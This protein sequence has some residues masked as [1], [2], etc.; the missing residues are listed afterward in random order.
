M[1]LIRRYLNTSTAC[2]RRYLN[3]YEDTLTR[4]QPS[5]QWGHGARLGLFYLIIGLFYLIIGLFYLI[6]GLFGHLCRSLFN[7]VTAQDTSPPSLGRVR[8]YTFGAPRVG[9]SEFAR[10]FDSLGIEAYRFVCLCVC[11]YILYIYTYTNTNVYTCIYVIYVYTHIYMYKYICIYIYICVCLCVCVCIYIHTLTYTY[12]HVCING[13]DIVARKY[14]H[15]HTHT[16]THTHRIVDSADIVSISV[17][18]GVAIVGLFASVV[19][20]FCNTCL[21]PLYR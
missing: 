17:K 19:G 6:I 16:H 21:T 7:E 3:T 18:A 10:F 20:L 9:N 4:P 12:M 13:A 11:V 5:V 8:M 14:I 2:G 15:T 1:W